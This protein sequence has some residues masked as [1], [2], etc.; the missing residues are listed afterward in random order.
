MTPTHKLLLE[1]GWY[2][3]HHGWWH[4]ELGEKPE[5]G[6]SLRQALQIEKEYMARDEE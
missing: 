4:D 6:I 1:A 5:K 3:I 2:R